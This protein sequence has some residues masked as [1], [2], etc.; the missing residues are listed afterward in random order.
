MIGKDIQVIAWFDESGK[1]TPLKFKYEEN[2]NIVISINRVI[3][4]TFEKIAG[5]QLWNFKCISNIKGIEREYLIKYDVLHGKWK[6]F[7]N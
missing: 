1:I 4:R 2:E 5:G 7:K 6:I 3:E